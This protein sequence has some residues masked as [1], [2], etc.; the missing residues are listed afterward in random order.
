MQEARGG[1]GGWRGKNWASALYYSSPVFDFKKN[2]A[3]AIAHQK[4]HTQPKAEK[5]LSS[6]RT[7]T[8]PTPNPLKK[9]CSVPKLFL[10]WKECVDW[11]QQVSKPLA[12]AEAI[13]GCP[14]LAI[15]FWLEYCVLFQIFL[16][17][18]CGDHTICNTK[19]LHFHSL[20]V[21]LQLVCLLSREMVERTQR[22][23]N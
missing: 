18:Q 9:Y 10:P 5:R 11:P 8:T 19:K 7:L 12:V 1:G 4:I 2:L 3:Q 16:S 20:P 15:S 21:C 6:P 23:L 14:W 13:V 17:H 22:R